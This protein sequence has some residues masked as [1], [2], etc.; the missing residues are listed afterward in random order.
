MDGLLSA[1]GADK[2]LT[3]YD[4][5]ATRVETAAGAVLTQLLTAAVLVATAATLSDHGQSRSLHSVGDISTAL[6]TVVG[7]HAR[8]LLFSV[9]VPGAAMVAAI[10]CSLSLAWGLGEVAGYKRSL[11]DHPTSA[12]WFYG[13]YMAAVAGSAYVVW[14]A[15]NLVSLNVAA[16]VV[17]APMLPLVVGL[18]IALSVIALPRQY[19]PRGTY[20]WLVCGIAAVVCVG[21]VVGAVLGFVS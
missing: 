12:P 9:R 3:R 15:P 6:A 1:S 7:A 16:Q 8:R 14:L 11:E 4:Q 10:V 13:V 21:G 2:R 17:N 20:L 18:L 19:R 5:A